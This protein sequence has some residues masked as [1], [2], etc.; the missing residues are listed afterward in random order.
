MGVSVCA[1]VLVKLTKANA[2]M[3]T[4]PVPDSISMP[5]P[6]PILILTSILIPSDTINAAQS[7][8]VGLLA[9]TKIDQI[10]VIDVSGAPLSFARSH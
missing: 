8:N 9:V 4:T 6:I 7:I 2:S 1:C 3:A 10:E 5:I